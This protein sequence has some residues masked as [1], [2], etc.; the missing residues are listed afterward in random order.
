M[1]VTE[2]AD[3]PGY[4]VVAVY[5]RVTERGKRPRKVQ[6]IVKGRRAA[7]RLE[8]TLKTER[9]R[10]SLV[11]RGETLGSYAVSYLASRRK[12]V[13]ARTLAGYRA[14]VD[15]YVLPYP[16][17][18]VSIGD[19]TATKVRG[20]YADVLENGARRRGRPVR[21]ETVR[22]L[23]RV[24]AMILKQATAE[25][26]LASN[27][28]LQVKPPKDDRALDGAREPGVDP[29]IAREFVR[30]VAE[31]PIG[32]LAAVALGTG[33]RRSELVALRWSDIDFAAGELTVS[34][35]IE[36]VRGRA[37]RKAP[38]T[39][40]S[41]RTVPFG[42]GVVAVLK[43]QKK[44]LAE[45]RLKYTA[46]GLW[47]DEGWV[48]PAMRVTATRDGRLLPAGRLW[49]PDALTQQWRQVMDDVN[50]RRLGEFVAAGG[51]PEDFEPWSF[52]PHALRHCYA[53]CQL[54][55]GVRDEIVS[56]RMGHSDSYITRKVYSHVI[57][58]ESREGVEV[59]DGLLEA[60]PRGS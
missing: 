28:C 10:G 56:R 44:L 16:I 41:R 9:E 7:E 34:G 19:V 3:R 33:L 42:P 35:K 59:A 39:K 29:E 11:A 37:E 4:Y 13:S 53:T 6:R 52:G 27:P 38:K 5:D 48:F 40:R 17:A 50:G 58:S 43:A 54:A 15:R 14:I 55:A 18:D 30:R 45:H 21:P 60:A 49:T 24:L 22:G 25:G 57:N 1:S 47:A 31:T 51:A 32:P 36:Q 8:R 26:L 2:L 23:H 20:L 12:E 46:D